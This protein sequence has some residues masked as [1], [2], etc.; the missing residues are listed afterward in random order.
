M[1][2]TGLP[3]SDS[4]IVTLLP[5]LDSILACTSSWLPSSRI[6]AVPG[7]GPVAPICGAILLTA[8][9]LTLPVTRTVSTPLD[10]LAAVGLG[11]S[12]V[13]E[14]VGQTGIG[15]QDR[16]DVVDVG[17][18]PEIL[19]VAAG[20]DGAVQVAVGDDEADAFQPLAQEED[21]GL[22]LGGHGGRVGQV[23]LSDSIGSS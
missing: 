13:G 18:R 1:T 16:R 23:A 22:A 8:S 7:T 17:G 12:E 21:V 4:V 19:E 11:I 15:I 9:A 14:H 20:G 2:V 3:H 5:G 10:G 6:H